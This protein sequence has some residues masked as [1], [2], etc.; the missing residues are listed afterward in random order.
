MAYRATRVDQQRVDCAVAGGIARDGFHLRLH[1]IAEGQYGQDAD[2]A[3][4]RLNGEVRS[5]AAREIRIVIRVKLD[6]GEVSVVH[7]G[8]DLVETCIDE[9]AVA[10]HV[11]RQIR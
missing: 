5:Q 11:A 8:G 6:T 9:D 3:G 2:R 4:C 10:F 7:G 1:V